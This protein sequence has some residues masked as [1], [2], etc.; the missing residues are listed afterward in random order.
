M[1]D[2]PDFPYWKT[3]RSS[4][5]EWLRKAKVQIENAGGEITE[6]GTIM[7]GG[8]EIVMLGFRLA[9]DV[10]RL[11]WP[12]LEHDP[13]ENAAAVR[14][15]ATMLY[16]DCKARCV[17]ARVKGGRWAFHAELVLPDGRMA[18]S[19]TDGDLLEKLPP[20]ARGPLALEDK[21][22]ENCP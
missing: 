20:M 9:D 18:G 8:R 13:T 17:A 12:V 4:P 14:Q 3:G 7:Q 6:S 21:S 11:I 2:A 22:P 15:A 5:D 19:L 16:H 1:P 10:F